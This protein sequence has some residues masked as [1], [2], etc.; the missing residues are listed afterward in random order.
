LVRDGD[1]VRSGQVGG[2]EV[3][4]AAEIQCRLMQGEAVDG[5]PEIQAIA[6]GSA[7][8]A[9][10]DLADKMD[11]EGSDG[12]GAAA[13]DRTGA[14]KLGTMP[15]RRLEADQVQD[16]VHRDLPPKLVIVDARHD[17]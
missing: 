16:I 5:D 9:L 4:D 1:E 8:E 13:R 6:A 10:I 12:S 11:R 14:A 17:C 15:P 3:Q 7:G 2:I